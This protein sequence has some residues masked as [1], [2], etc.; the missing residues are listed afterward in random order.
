METKYF[1][2]KIGYGA[3]DYISITDNELSKAIVAQGTGRVVVLSGGTVSGN[4]IISITPDWNREL[5]F[6]R[7]YKLTGEDYQKIGSKKM[8]EYQELLE[9]TSINIER[10]QQGFSDV[11][12]EKKNVLSNDIK[13][14]GD[15]LRK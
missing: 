15:V 7:D 2:V 14:L 5:G 3:D 6:N 4:S 8:S 11:L 9:I 10:K 13:S 1:K 12:P